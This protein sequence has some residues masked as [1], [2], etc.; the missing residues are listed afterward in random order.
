MN[1][2]HKI[3]CALGATFAL[4][5]LPSCESSDARADDTV[6]Q[7]AE[8]DSKATQQDT[9]S[10]PPKTNIPSKRTYSKSGFDVTPLAKSDIAELAKKLDPEAFRVT[11]S[12]GTEP[13]FCGN[14]V[15]NKKQGEYCCVVC[16]L[17]LFSSNSKFNSGTGWPSFF[18]PVDPA[19]VSE[20]VDGGHGMERTEI[21]CARCG[22][23]LGHVFEDGPAPTGLRYCL[24]SAALV[25][26]EKGST[27]PAS[28]EPVK[29]QTAYF[30]G[31]CFWGIEHI[32]Q[33][34]PGV[35]TA[36]SGFMQGTKENPTY[37]EVCEGDTGHA[38][39][40]KVV[41][42]PTVI[43]YRQLV[44]GFFLMHDPTEV[45]RQGPDA[46]TQYRSGVF[47]A[48]PEQLAQAKEVVSKL[49]SDKKFSRP[50]VTQVELAKKFY[51]AEEYHQDYVD[52]TGRAC[53]VGNPWPQVLGVAK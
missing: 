26:H 36:E 49:T 4:L 31:G 12:S 23:H 17:P 50:I 46:G 8:S 3:L 40:V 37:K 9:H 20:K 51:P 53:H 29:S 19:H 25:F 41:F 6:K 35:I 48:T 47:C 5:L 39:T 7:Q 11:Q 15:D 52:K 34:A 24:N 28:S 1:R 27:M 42:D 21:N 45:N 14:L 38:E 18:S 33:E 13:A 30:A 16:G 43:T 22:A 10:M 44:D 2:P 32:F